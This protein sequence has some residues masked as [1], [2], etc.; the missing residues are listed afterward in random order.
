[1]KVSYIISILA[2]ASTSVLAAPADTPGN[3][4]ALS[5]NK[6]TPPVANNQ[7]TPATK[8]PKDGAAI[9]AE[10]MK[11]DTRKLP[12][13]QLQFFN[14]LGPEVWDQLAALRVKEKA[15]KY[16]R[17]NAWDALYKGSIPDWNNLSTAKPLKTK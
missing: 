3:Q 13:Q 1:M 16:Q 15:I 5:T 17:K 4:A 6:A 14:G 8:P 7:A 12:P 2:V 9:K 11:D 10:F